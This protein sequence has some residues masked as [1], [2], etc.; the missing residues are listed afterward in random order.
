MQVWSNHPLFTYVIQEYLKL[1]C[2]NEDFY[3]HK[4]MRFF[5]YLQMHAI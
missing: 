5:E 3:V 2:K 1:L 4:W